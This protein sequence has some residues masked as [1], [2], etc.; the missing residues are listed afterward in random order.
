MTAAEAAW[1]TRLA[2]VLSDVELRVARLAAEIAAARPDR[3]G[4]ECAERAALAGRELGRVGLAAAD[5]AVRADDRDDDQAGPVAGSP[6]A[7]SSR[8][9]RAGPRLPGTSG[10]RV[11]DTPGIRLPE[12]PPPS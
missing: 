11:D 3:G 5:L 8:R 1:S 9:G 12:L 7:P 4:R 10:E 2:A 6:S